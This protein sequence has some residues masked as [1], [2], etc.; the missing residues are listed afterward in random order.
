MAKPSLSETHP[1]L[2]AQADGWDPTVITAGSNKKLQWICP[3]GHGYVATPNNRSNGKGCPVCAGRKVLPGVNDLGTTHP[4]LTSQALFDVSKVSAGTH[5]RCP[6]RCSHGHEWEAPV[7]SRASGKGCPVCSGH[8]VAAGT[9]DLATT[10]PD[11]AAQA[12]FDTTRV[13]A[14]S[15]RRLEWKCEQGHRWHA[16]V[17]SRVAGNGCAVCSNYL[18]VTGVNDLATT[19]PE[20]VAQACFDP[21]TVTAG[22]QKK[23]LWK[24]DLGHEW[25]AT[26]ANRTRN[27]SGCGVCANYTLAV[28]INDLATTHPELAAQACFDP[29]MVIAG[30]NKRLQ[31]QCSEGHTWTATGNHRL[32]GKGCP[33]CANQILLPGYNDM[34]TTHPELVAEAIFDPA[35]VIAGTN[36]R[37]RWRCATGHEWTATGNSRAF[38][39]TGCP[40]CAESGFK[41]GSLGWLYLLKHDNWVAQQ[42]GISNRPEQ[43]LAT[44]RRNGWTVLDLRGPMDGYLTQDW[45][46]DILRWLR[47]RGVSASTG[48]F[49]GYTESWSLD[50]FQANSLTEL[51]EAVR[52]SE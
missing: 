21:S 40:D 35:T 36:R 19:H 32:S 26:A 30:T 16:T 7:Y 52:N 44:H 14:G 42:I 1:E 37:L 41:P 15:N 11:L 29:T 39:G 2:A 22:S 4:H 20:L 8:R 6:W 5:R 9:N 13:S 10:H 12:C 38:R 28:G 31:W 50:D 23:L 49:D 48:D 47:K 45:E 51:M 33:Y 27:G 25:M 17:A 34:A 18:V 43:R 3:A 24:C 46:R